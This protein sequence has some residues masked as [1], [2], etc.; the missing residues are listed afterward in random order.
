[1]RTR[2]GSFFERTCSGV[3]VLKG[4][5][6]AFRKE[7]LKFVVADTAMALTRADAGLI[8]R[9]REPGNDGAIDEGDILFEPGGVAE[10]QGGYDAGGVVAVALA[11]ADSIR[12]GKMVVHVGIG[13]EDRGVRGYGNRSAR[14]EGCRLETGTLASCTCGRR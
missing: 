10:F 5:V 8:E 11:D 12:L 2:R 1:M 14:Q 7:F 6:G 13:E 3:P 4:I 9:P